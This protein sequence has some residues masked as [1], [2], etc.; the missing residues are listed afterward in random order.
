[1]RFLTQV[2][3]IQITA[4][5]SNGEIDSESDGRNNWIDDEINDTLADL[6][7][8]PSPPADDATLLRRI[9][10]DLTGRLPQPERIREYLN[11][12]SPQKI[13]HEVDRLLASPEFTEYWTFKLAQWLRVRAGT[14]DIAGTKRYFA[15]LGEQVAA[16]RPLDALVADLIVGSGDSHR[17][18]PPN[19]HRS[20]ADA[21]AEAEHVSET[22][23]AIRLRCANCHNHPLD[24][25]TQD[26]YHGLAAI[27][28]RL[29]RGRVVKLRATGD[30]VHPVTDEAARPR[31]P[32]ER[33]LTEDTRDGRHELAAWLTGAGNRYFA[34]AWVNR[35]WESMLGRGLVH[36]SDDL[37]ESNPASHPALLDRL[38]ADFAENDHDI[39]HTLRLVASSAAYQRSTQTQEANRH[40]DQFYSHAA[41]RGLPPEVLLDMLCDATGL[42]NDYRDIPLQPIT[43][44]YPYPSLASRAIK[45][46]D[47]RWAAEELGPLAAC[48]LDEP[49]QNETPPLAR[50]DDLA[51]QLHW[52]NGPLVNDRLAAPDSAFRQLTTSNTPTKQLV[53]QYYLRTLSRLPSEAESAFWQEELGE[54]ADEQKCEDFAWSLLS[55]PEFVTNH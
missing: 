13:E 42:P 24:R 52:L 49:C 50:L 31:I 6:R 53:E 3:A 47:T 7:L 34:R 16:R 14:N 37:R 30:V 32:G 28:A 22:L 10:L 26:D 39:R 15:W 5:Y 40:D 35:L 2:Q 8:P 27:F 45:L 43:D 19:F 17:E 48:Q 38:A 29:D 9:T 51:N 12:K 20:A 25:W 54:E 44:K 33:F 36:P 1:V 11:D 55:C 41:R 46:Y 18:G 4:P 21:R 23:L